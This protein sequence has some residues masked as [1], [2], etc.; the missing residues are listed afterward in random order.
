MSRVRTPAVFKNDPPPV[1]PRRGEYF[2][3]L[4]PFNQL[5][6]PDKWINTRHSKY[7]DASLP[8][9]AFTPARVRF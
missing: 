3:G 1:R 8:M 5:G 6:D 9:A 4:Q 2:K 7:C